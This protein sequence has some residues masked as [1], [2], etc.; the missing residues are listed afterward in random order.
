M[1]QA[2]IKKTLREKGWT[3]WYRPCRSIL[4]LEPSS[5]PDDVEFFLEMARLHLLW[6][7]VAAAEADRLLADLGPLRDVGLAIDAAT[8]ERLDV[9]G[10]ELA[11]DRDE[12]LRA[13]LWT[14]PA[15]SVHATGDGKFS[16][17]G[18]H[19]ANPS[20]TLKG[21]ARISAEGGII[22]GYTNDPAWLQELRL[23]F[24]RSPANP[25]DPAE[26]H[27]EH[28][29]ALLTSADYPGRIDLA[30][31]DCLPS[32]TVA[33]EDDLVAA[34]ADNMRR[35]VFEIEQIG[36]SPTA[37]LFLRECAFPPGE[38]ISIG[39]RRPETEL[40]RSF[41]DLLE[42]VQPFG[43]PP[44]SALHC[45][46]SRHLGEGR[47]SRRLK[48]LLES[49]DL[50]AFKKVDG[51]KCRLLRLDCG[52]ALA[53]EDEDLLSLVIWRPYDQEP[54]QGVHWSA[55]ANVSAV[56]IEGYDEASPEMVERILESEADFDMLPFANPNGAYPGN[57]LLAAA[58]R[59]GLTISDLN[60][61]LVESVR[62]GLAAPHVAGWPE[63]AARTRRILDRI[64]HTEGRYE[65]SLA[66]VFMDIDCLWHSVGPWDASR[67]DGFD[68]EET[69][70]AF[71]E[72]A[73]AGGTLLDIAAASDEDYGFYD[74][75]EIL[76]DAETSEEVLKMLAEL[77]YEPE[78]AE[79]E[80]P[81][82]KSQTKTRAVTSTDRRST[83]QRRTR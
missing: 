83:G 80:P 25:I 54:D 24:R 5:E 51:M 28:L 30:L 6:S 55:P 9:T 22:L 43:S 75:D 62:R 23:R 10:G 72:I 18:E 50:I 38:W 58:H 16:T 61:T 40:Y 81:V 42:R 21:H 63:R 17:D 32:E 15:V 26:A 35:T 27:S 4:V 60:H 34:V 19:I 13:A 12:S 64:G 57:W 70:L 69:V 52:V 11:Q 76:L 20:G 74:E 78:I 36:R 79:A 73:A 66:A 59:A 45:N 48:S 39:G 49:G 31:Y 67:D 7:G 53:A 8:G 46:V 41:T 77:D 56:A 37:D 47:P 65:E 33:S 68:L 44:G 2:K 71:R 29:D 82:G 3:A 14:G 1:G